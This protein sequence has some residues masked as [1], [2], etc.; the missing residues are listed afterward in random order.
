MGKAC[1]IPDWNE[2]RGDK[3]RSFSADVEHHFGAKKRN[4]VM[5]KARDLLIKFDYRSNLVC[6]IFTPC[7]LRELKLL[8]DISVCSLYRLGHV[9]ALF[10][11]GLS[12]KSL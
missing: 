6:I 7:F 3:L 4:S 10:Y 9:F 2:T 8:L 5:A 11:S 1:L 12:C